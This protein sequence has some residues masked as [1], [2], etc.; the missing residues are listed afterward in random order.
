MDRYGFYITDKYRRARS[1]AFDEDKKELERCG[2]WRDMMVNWNL[3][4]DKKKKERVRKGIPNAVRAEAW[5]LLLGIKPYR[6]KYPV[7]LVQRMVVNLDVRL[8]DEVDRDVGRA[9][10]SHRDFR[11]EGSPGQKNL[12]RVLLWYAAV[13][14]EVGFCQGM[15]F[16]AATLLVYMDVADAFH[17]MLAMMNLPIHGKAKM[18]EL[19]LPKMV[20]IQQMMMVFKDLVA[21]HMPKVSAHLETEGVQMAMFVTPWFMTLYCRDFSFDLVSRIWDSFVNGDSKI[22]YRVA[23]ALLTVSQKQV[24]KSSFED[25]L[26]LLPNLPT[27]IDA[28][29]VWNAVWSKV[30][31][32][33]AEIEA[34]EE[35]YH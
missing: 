33:T 25:I 14:P 15:S 19:F 8:V 32:T 7:E 12:R 11:R 30:K 23:L 17:C 9:F 1:K 18:R 22:I 35:T 26:A 24:L 16:I 10:P 5:P 6:D 13:D 3:F 2:K 29:E 28:D 34:L 27:E 21:N 20:R 4:S 31:V